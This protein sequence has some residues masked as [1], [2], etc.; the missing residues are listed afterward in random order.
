MSVF[1]HFD[2]LAPFYERVISPHEPS[3][4]IKLA[5]LPVEGYLLDVG[6]GTGRVASALRGMASR[7]IVADLSLGMLRQAANKNGLELTCTSSEDLPFDSDSFD[8]IIMVDALHHVYS[9]A[10]T[11][12]E[13]WRVLKPGGLIVIEEPDI[14]TL[15]VKIVAALEKLALMR[16]HFVSPSHIQSLFS[17]RNAKTYIEVDGYTSWVV[18]KKV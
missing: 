6:G 11:A 1:D 13:L 15:S 18:I 3:R 10:D 14:R 12:H 5:L 2:I 4:L 9:Y 16:S 17:Y 8:R 7:I